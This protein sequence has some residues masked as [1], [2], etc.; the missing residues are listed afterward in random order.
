MLIFILIATIAFLS[1]ILYVN[2]WSAREGKKADL[3]YAAAL[4]SQATDSPV[5][6]PY[7]TTAAA[8]RFFEIHGTTQKKYEILMDPVAYAGYVNLTG[9]EAVVVAFMHSSGLTVATHLLPYQLG[10]DIL[11][12][13]QKGLY[14]QKILQA[15]K[16]NSKTPGGNTGIHNSN[17]QTQ[18]IKTLRQWLE[19][20][21]SWQSGKGISDDEL[22]R[23]KQLVLGDAVSGEHWFPKVHYVPKEIL[24]M[25]ELEDLHLQLNDLETLPPVICDISSLKKLRLGGNGLTSLP[26]TIGKLKNLELLTLWSNN[27]SALPEEIGQLVNLKALDLSWNAALDSLPDSIVHLNKL[28]QFSWDCSEEITLTEQQEIWLK[29]LQAKGCKIFLNGLP[30]HMHIA[31]S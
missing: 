24:L 7:G 22:I 16:H 27:L 28:E 14:I 18:Q 2:A 23:V 29:S 31:H 5:E 13:M 4:R 19:N 1:L 17:R 20:E 8:S 10:N 21:T 6:V 30:Y 26:K 15:Y 3:I 9:E 25:E 12:L 11:S